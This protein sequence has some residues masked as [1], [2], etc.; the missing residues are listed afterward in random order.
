MVIN[1]TAEDGLVD[2]VKNTFDGDHPC[3]LCNVIVEA[4]KESSKE[5][6]TQALFD[7]SGLCLKNLFPADRFVLD[8]PKFVDLVII[9]FADPPG[10]AILRNIS[11]EMPPPRLV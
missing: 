6:Q 8:E 3:D 5:Q 4:K 1:Y 7:G 11:P 2:G 10:V 9:S